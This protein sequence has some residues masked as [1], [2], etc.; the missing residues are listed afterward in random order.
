MLVLLWEMHRKHQCH[1]ESSLWRSSPRRSQESTWWSHGLKLDCRSA[2]SWVSQANSLATNLL[3]LSEIRRS[4][5]PFFSQLSPSSDEM[6]LKRTKSIICR[7]KGSKTSTLLKHCNST[8]SASLSKLPSPERQRSGSF[9]ENGYINLSSCLIKL[10]IGHITSSS[11]NSYSTVIII[12]FHA[13]QLTIWKESWIWGILMWIR[14]FHQWYIEHEW[15]DYAQHVC[16]AFHHQL[17]L[18]GAHAKH[19]MH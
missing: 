19:L 1:I 3:P 8:S 17:L 16:W 2:R 6:M 10:S 12:A 7:I 15:Y 13:L 11:S 14:L 18:Q 5:E 4:A 9:S